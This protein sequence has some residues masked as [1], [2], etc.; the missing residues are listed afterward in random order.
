MHL[1]KHHLATLAACLVLATFS[2][3]ATLSVP[4]ARA[5]DD[6]R[7]VVDLPTRAQGLVSDAVVRLDETTLE[8]KNSGRATERQ[9]RIVT[10]FNEDG[11][12]AAVAELWYD[13]I[14]RL[15]KI[16]GALYDATG[17][18]VRKL[19]KD[20]QADY[21][22]IGGATLYAEHRVRVLSMLDDRYPYTVELEIEIDHR[23]LLHYPTWFPQRFSYPVQEAS[24]ELS[25]PTA[26][27]VRY[28]AQN[29]P[30]SLGS[31]APSV[32]T[33]GDRTIMRWHFTGFDEPRDEPGSPEWPDRSPAIFL[34]ATH[35]EIE[36]RPGRM[37]TWEDLG[38][39]YYH[40]AQG[41]QRLPD[42]VAQEALATLVGAE[43]NREKARRLYEFM[44]ARTRYVSVQL[45]IGGWQPFDAI[46]V[47]ER[48]YG[49]CKALTNYMQALLLAA[50]IEAY[51]ALTYRSSYRRP[52]RPAFPSSA[53]NHVILMVPLQETAP[54]GSVQADT[55]WLES[56]S[57][58]IPFGHV[59]SDNEGR[60]VLVA[61]PTGSH[62]AVTPSSTPEDNR[63]ARTTDL[64]LDPD[65]SAT[66]DF[67]TR[68]TGNQQDRM[69][70]SYMQ[71][72]P[73]ERDERLRRSLDLSG[74]EV[75]SADFSEIEAGGL[76]VA[77]PVRLN[78]PRYAARVGKRLFVPLSPVERWSGVP[79]ADT[80]RTQPIV[81][82]TYTFLDTDTVRIA[83]PAGFRV[84]AMPAPV[85]VDAPFGLYESAAKLSEDGTTLIFERRL[86]VDTPKL[87]PTDFDA[88][89]DALATITR[90]DA[91]KVVLVQE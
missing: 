53:F 83:L 54:D 59:G 73:R 51:P 38:A 85:R 20:D 7:H 81:F 88:F 48:G 91:A 65:G 62:L 26:L 50:G 75:E 24:L 21:S 69:R 2:A 71:A 43:T 35:F 80:I 40:L 79:P 28:L 86:R 78:V 1:P 87:A 15:G 74:F 57:Q 76:S 70:R 19:G 56:T 3:L 68:Y 42:A 31:T 29:F 5:Q 63:Q 9:R 45:D 52:V 8:V 23:G 58:T 84:E 39:W 11:R 33:D 30:D 18:R 44:Q 47:G 37:D 61:K 90:A 14:R 49:D 27:G 36:G 22:A 82:S 32:G 64:A 89:R 60:H 16:K 72:T 67:T 34:A 77:L 10:V 6:P 25:A 55:L 13:D 66:L 46:Y 12:D 4:D 17:K 41:R